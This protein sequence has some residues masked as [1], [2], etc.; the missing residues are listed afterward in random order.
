VRT[1]L[2][3]PAVIVL[4]ITA[5]PGLAKS[6]DDAADLNRATTKRRT[7]PL[8]HVVVYRENGRFCGW[9]AN[10][11]V[12]N[13][14]NEILVCFD[15]CYFK[16]PDRDI[17]P[18]EHHVDWDK[19]E[20][21]V[22]ARSLDGGQ[23]WQLEKPEAFA[24]PRRDQRPVPSPGPINFTHPDFAMRI[25]RDR[26]H[27][28]YDRGRNWQGPYIFPELGAELR[29]R[30][31]YI[32]NS[33]S[34]CMLFLSA[35]NGPLCV[36]TTDGGRTFSV[37]SNIEPNPDVRAIMPSTVGI[38]PAQIVSALRRLRGEPYVSWIDAYVSNDKGR[39]WAFLSKVADADN[40]YWNGNPPSMV[41]LQDGRLCVTYG[42][43]AFP[44][45]IRAKLSSDNGKTW[46]REII[47]REDGRNWDLGYTRT[48]QRADGKLVTIYY[49]STQENPQQ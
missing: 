41:R 45:G 14:G 1:K 40:K 15:L 5:A 33:Q 44:Y 24:I 22:M 27:I 48:V 2:F 38:S 13:W 36:L 30:T 23:S 32:V 4:F 6:I 49:Y 8:T 16:E 39:T 42:Y 43:R 20:G 12:W 31:D 3:P 18:T 29:S 21:I 46:G 25:R 17:D 10:N 19:P 37:L 34:E 47:L 35:K 7:V 9:P 11:G 26:F 28:S